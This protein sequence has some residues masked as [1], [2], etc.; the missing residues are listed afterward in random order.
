MD[1]FVISLDSIRRDLIRSQ[2]SVQLLIQLLFLCESKIQE[3]LASAPCESITYKD[4]HLVGI[5]RPLAFQDA[6]HDKLP[7]SDP[8]GIAGITGETQVAQYEAVRRDLILL[9]GELPL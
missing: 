2:K 6:G 4:L 3:H 7:L 1:H 8:D 5:C 9:P